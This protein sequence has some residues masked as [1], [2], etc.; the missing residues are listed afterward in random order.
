MKDD[1][2]HFSPHRLSDRLGVNVVT[3]VGSRTASHTEPGSPT[4]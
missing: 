2:I 3:L 4:S 1:T